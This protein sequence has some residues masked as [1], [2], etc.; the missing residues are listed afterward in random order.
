MTAGSDLCP[1]CGAYW[2]CDC[3]RI[4]SVTEMLPIF[5]REIPGFQEAREWARLIERL[6]RIHP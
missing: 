1:K 4:P 6:S 2:D 5:D 3:R